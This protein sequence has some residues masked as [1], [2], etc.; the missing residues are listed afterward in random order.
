MHRL[1]LIPIE[2]SLGFVL[3]TEVQAR[4]NAKPGG[5]LYLT[6]TPNGLLLTANN[7]DFDEQVSAGPEIIKERRAVLSTLAKF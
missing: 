7:P 5:V 3:P 4:L 1:A 6:E 2:S